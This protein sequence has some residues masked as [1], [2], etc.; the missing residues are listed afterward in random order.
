MQRMFKNASF[1]FFFFLLAGSF[2]TWNYGLEGEELGEPRVQARLFL[3]PKTEIFQ[4][5]RTGMIKTPFPG[6]RRNK[7]WC[8][9]KP[10]IVRGL[11]WGTEESRV[12]RLKKLM[13]SA[14]HL[15]DSRTTSWSTWHR[16]LVIKQAFP[17]ILI[18]DKTL[19]WASTTSTELCL[20]WGTTLASVHSFCQTFM[21]L[22]VII[23]CAIECVFTQHIFAQYISQVT[24]LFICPMTG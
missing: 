13:P 21:V 17:W 15:S 2:L 8:F 16:Q 24:T 14:Q 11:H 7:Q 22:Y 9:C 12:S 4:N 23:I 5:S 20:A 18:S 10:H 6:N 3:F 1:V 19:K